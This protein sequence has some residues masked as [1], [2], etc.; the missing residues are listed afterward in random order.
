[1]GKSD[2]C[3]DVIYNPQNSVSFSPTAGFF[4]R[5]IQ[6][7]KITAAQLAALHILLQ[8][9]VPLCRHIDR[10]LF[11]DSLTRWKRARIGHR[12]HGFPL[13]GQVP[14]R[15]RVITNAD[16]VRSPRLFGYGLERRVVGR[17]L[18]PS[19][20]LFL[21]RMMM[22]NHVVRTRAILVLGLLGAFKAE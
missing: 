19:L 5:A 9:R 2:E 7:E 3:G 8:I 11:P 16:L 1:M 17:E 4:Q 14:R 22:N 20:L 21:W 10:G 18:R 6:L 13:A 15:K 12:V